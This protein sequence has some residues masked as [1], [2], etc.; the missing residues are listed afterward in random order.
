MLAQGIVLAPKVKV[1]GE[2]I[3]IS[4]DNCRLLQQQERER[5]G[6]FYNN[7]KKFYNVGWVKE[8]ERD[9]VQDIE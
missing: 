6:H 5:K 1:K 4:L 7:K 3:K 8:G 2:D 9:N